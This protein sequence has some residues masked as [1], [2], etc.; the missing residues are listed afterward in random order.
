MYTL[1]AKTK[2]YFPIVPKNR[3]LPNLGANPALLDTNE[4]ISEEANGTRPNTIDICKVREEFPLLYSAF[5][6][7]LGTHTN[8]S[9]IRRVRE[10]LMLPDRCSL[11]E[12][13][14]V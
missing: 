12:D 11:R 10:D 14:L 1:Y 3:E 2:A 6:E 8:G 13:S 9:S 4:K 5:S 7:T